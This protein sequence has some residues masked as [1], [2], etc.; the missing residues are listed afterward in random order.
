[1]RIGWVRLAVAAG[2]PLLLAACASSRSLDRSVAD[3]SANTQ[4]QGVLFSDRTHD[5]SDVDITIFEGRLMLTGTM[6]SEDG[7]GKLLD[8]A[9]KARGVS[10]VIDEILID[11]K[12]SFGQGFEDARIDQTL[13]AK[14]IAAG[15]V[16][17]T[18]YKF[19]VSKAVVYIIGAARD[20]AERDRALELARTVA[21]VEQVV[22]HIALRLPG[23]AQ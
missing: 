7:R 1:M 15:D 13:R 16:A 18:R 11:E 5:Y 8:N 21:G 22:S 4:I 3:L 17:S 9:W 2:A 6:R 10:Q 20:Q 12:T 19:S 14:L 23:D